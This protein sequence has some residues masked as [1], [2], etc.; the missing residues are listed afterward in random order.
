[1]ESISIKRAAI[2]NFISRYSTIFIQ[3]LI[4]SILAR[5]LTPDDYGI[6]AIIT[7]FISF[8]SIIADMGIGPAIIQYKNLNNKEI[9]DIF[10]FTFFVAII[11]TVGFIGFSYPLSIFYTNKIYIKLGMILSIGIFFNVLNIV[12]NSLLLKNK[13]FK[14]LGIR[15]IIITIICGIITIILALNNF[16]Y[17]SLVINSVLVGFL[18]FIF[19]ILY[20]KIRIYFSFSFE[21]IKKI[22]EFSSYQFGFN[23]INYF[24]R[25]LDNLLIGKFMGQ[26][27]L[28]YYDKAYKLML[29]PVQNLTHAI[30]PILHPILSEYADNKEIIYK[31]YIK[32]INILAYIGIFISVFCF[33]SS[34]EI[35][36]IMFGKGWELSIPTFK[37]LS[38]GIIFQMI[39]SSSGVIFQSTNSTRYMF[40]CGIISTVIMVISILVGIL[41]KNLSLLAI[42]LTLSFILNFF[43]TYYIMVIKVFNK[44]FLDF[45]SE[46][47]PIIIIG[48]IMIILNN[49]FNNILNSINI[50]LLRATMKFIITFIGYLIGIIVTG[51]IK[52]I[53]IYCSQYK[54][55]KEV[56]N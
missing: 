54:S 25:N 32:I 11:I 28:G 31:Q 38:I 18:T 24:A 14:T 46:F 49:I 29:Y 51:D 47:K 30:T 40:R 35:I 43:Q 3:L 56:E 48:L 55:K 42:C 16:K 7:V 6:V 27:S 33:F 34:Q 20:S 37:I 8:F 21:S 50:L 17:Y 45:L 2:I 36:T 9:S 19:N 44:K 39:L 4:N 22:R 53:I 1:M 26:V 23:F 41:S 13:K 52:Y 10:I 12:P 15:N 5:L